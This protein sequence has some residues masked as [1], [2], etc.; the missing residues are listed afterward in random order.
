MTQDADCARV[1]NECG[2]QLSETEGF[3]HDMKN[4]VILCEPCDRER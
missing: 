1:C 2:R 4:D 3:V